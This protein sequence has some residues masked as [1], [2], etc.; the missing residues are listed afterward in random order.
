MHGRRHVDCLACASAWYSNFQSRR[1]IRYLRDLK[2]QRHT[3]SEV[4]GFS[5]WRGRRRCGGSGRE[6]KG[7]ASES[8][9]PGLSSG[10]WF[11]DAMSSRSIIS[12]SM[13]AGG[14]SGSV[15]RRPEGASRGYC[16]I[17]T[18][19]I[20]VRSHFGA[21]INFQAGTVRRSPRICGAGALNGYGA[22]RKSHICGSVIATMVGPS[23]N[24]A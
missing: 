1:G 7:E 12:E 4:E 9:L 2:S 6:A 22:S 24:W 16:G 23:S 17:M 15:T 3:R 11:G 18:F 10:I 13:P 21:T 20:P 14:Y 8:G 5:F 19:A